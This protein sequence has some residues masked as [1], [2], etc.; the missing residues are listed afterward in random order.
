MLSLTSVKMLQ[1]AY[2]NEAHTEAQL[3][4]LVLHLRYN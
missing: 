2:C 1:P 4:F 3:S